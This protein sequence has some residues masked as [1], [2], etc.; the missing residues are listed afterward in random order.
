MISWDIKDPKPNFDE[1][2]KDFFQNASGRHVYCFTWVAQQKMDSEE[3]QAQVNLCRQF[4]G[5][6]NVA[7][8]VVSGLE[9]RGLYP[10]YKST[11]YQKSVPVPAMAWKTHPMTG[12]IIG[13]VLRKSD[14]QPLM[15]AWVKVDSQPETWLSSA[16]GFFAILN[17]APKDDYQLHVTKKDVGEASSGPVKVQAGQAASIEV[18]L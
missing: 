16:D 6:G 18:R 12:V 8:S 17:L 10:F 11:V 15:D 4:G 14:G 13:R 3:F 9:S 7:F 5:Q 2:A 1:L